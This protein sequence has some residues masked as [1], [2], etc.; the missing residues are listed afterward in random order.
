MTRSEERGP[1]GLASIGLFLQQQGIC[2][3]DF[4]RALGISPEKERPGSVLPA[5]RAKPDIFDVAARL[6]ENA[7]LG[8]HFAEWVCAQP[9][10]HFDVLAFAVRSCATLGE[11]YR[12]VERYACLIHETTAYSLIVDEQ[13]ARFVYGRRDGAALPRQ[14]AECMLAVAI[15]Q[16]RRSVDVEIDPIEVRF[17]HTSST[18]TSE[19]ER[20]FRAPIRYNSPRNEI[21]LHPSHLDLAQRHHE[22]RLRA[23]LERQLDAMLDRL[24]QNDSFEARVKREMAKNLA[25][26][27]TTTRCVA[28]RMKM[29]E[30]SLQ[31]RLAEENTTLRRI[32]TD[33]RDE[34]AKEYLQDPRRTIQEVAFLLGFGETSAFHRAF[35]RKTGMTPAEY[36][37]AGRSDKNQSTSS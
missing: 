24:P 10:A 15:L 35:K 14:N 3:Q 9:E 31:R 13:E 25:H 7:H 21:V 19:C 6:S 8:L 26:G 20:I 32:L 30:R 33:L 36:Q 11:H 12:M 4:Q 16:A 5:D 2:P 17:A 22:P 28:T 1:D 18:H 29:S 23:L 37:R 27:Q 34:M